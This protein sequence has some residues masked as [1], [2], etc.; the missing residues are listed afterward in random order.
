MSALTKDPSSPPRLCEPGSVE[1]ASR[2]CLSSQAAPCEAGYNESFNEKLR[3]ELLNGEILYTLEEALVLTERWRQHYNTVRP[4]SFSGNRP[5]AL[6]TV[7]S[8]PVVP[9]Y[10]TLRPAQ[11]GH[12]Q[13][14]LLS[15]ALDR[16][17]T[18]DQ[19]DGPPISGLIDWT[20]PR[21]SRN[22]PFH[23]MS[24]SIENPGQ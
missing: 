6:E 3:D 21:P 18:A 12:D 15:Y 17:S 20:L 24:R 16:H 9:A 2:R 14:P 11:Q 19:I 22:R 5:P 7:L 4:H 8:S 10:A 13:H 23:Q 1:S